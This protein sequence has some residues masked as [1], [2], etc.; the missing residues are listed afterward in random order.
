MAPRRL[1]TWW[2]DFSHAAMRS[3]SPAVGH[4]NVQEK[5]SS[6][7][8]EAG[9]GALSRRLGVFDLILLG[10]G[11][12][13]GAGIFVVTGT[14]ANDTGPGVTVSFALAGLACVANAL[15]YAELAS[16]F[17]ALVGG[18]YLYAYSAFN[19]LVAFMVFCQL[20]VDYHIGAASITRSLAGYL[21]NLLELIPAL[22]GQIPVWFGPGGKTFFG[23][24]FSI[25]VLAPII[26]LVLTTVLC[27]GV[28]ESAAVNA[29]MTV[30][31]VV[32]VLVVIVLGAFEVDT[33]NW[34]P[35]A[36]N[37]VP[38]IVTGATVAYFA[39]VGFDAVANSAEESRRPKRD[40]PIGILVSL[41]VCALL[42]VGVCLVIT[43]MVPYQ[44]LAGDA[45]LA[46]AFTERG[47]PFITALISIG[48]VAGL[49]TTVLV[50]LYVQSRLYLG[51]GRDGL[52]PS[53]FA[54][55]HVRHHTPVMAQIWC[56]SVAGV[57]ATFFDVSHLSR[58]LSVG[59]L[60]GYSVVCGC[61]LILR[62]SQNDISEEKPE[63][64]FLTRSQEATSCL[65]GVALCGFAVGLFFRFSLHYA[66]IIVGLLVSIGLAVPMYIR[67]V[68]KHPTGFMCPGV[69]TVPLLGLYVNMFLFA[70]LHWEGWVRFVILGSLSVGFY[71]L[72]GQYNAKHEPLRADGYTYLPVDT[73]ERNPDEAQL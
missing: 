26:L 27:Q 61:V 60:S 62:A 22:S 1:A 55:I 20:M 65:V 3:K 52:L 9:E 36:P 28:R 4:Q 23:G 16:R 63:R 71:A 25:N 17:P 57:L 54:R 6:S 24:F 40:L 29:V 32:I 5:P 72:Y 18:A 58:I 68:F 37:G 13:I 8:S 56:G 34:T 7:S 70:Q 67:Q 10:I 11:A 30:T 46:E 51:L 19:E 41:I 45:P 38:A 14:I 50:G 66:L 39:Y 59:T 31:K 73:Q 2:S 53:L 43:G 64:H 35:F 44:S 21:V 12:S 42:Y 47:L 48:A 15:C 69:P 33:A 49:T